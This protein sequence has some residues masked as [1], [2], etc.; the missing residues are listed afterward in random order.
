MIKDKNLYEN[1]DSFP[2]LPNSLTFLK[3]LRFAKTKYSENTR[4]IR[5]FTF[6][7]MVEVIKILVNEGQMYND[8]ELTIAMLHNLL[9]NTNTSEFEI[10]N[11]FGLKV[12][13]EVKKLKKDPFEPFE[14][15]A[16]R[17]MD[18]NKNITL[19]KILVADILYIVR[20]IN[21]VNYPMNKLNFKTQATKMMMTYD[22]AMPFDLKARTNSA[23]K[24]M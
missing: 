21:D 2:E 19:R 3:A 8:E 24:F 1:K 15:F 5:S 18:T 11:N 4:D 20:N 10:Q 12:T 13:E 16:K 14:T 9:V 17:V 23:L 7:D 6:P 22:L